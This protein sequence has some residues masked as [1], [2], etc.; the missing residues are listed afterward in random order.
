MLN[1]N[2][3]NA[4]FT[5]L[6]MYLL[7]SLFIYLFVVVFCLFILSFNFIYFVSS[8]LFYLFLYHPLTLSWSLDQC[9]GPYNPC[10]PVYIMLFKYLNTTYMCTPSLLQPIY[11]RPIFCYMRVRFGH[12]LTLMGS[13]GFKGVYKTCVVKG[14]GQYLNTELSSK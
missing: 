6:Q 12:Q 13:K 4:L 10:S 11:V 7:S 14:N 3:T 9:L 8:I 5:V 2:L 1:M